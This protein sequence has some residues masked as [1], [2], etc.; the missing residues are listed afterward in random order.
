MGLVS[1][2]ILTIPLVFGT[3]LFAQDNA[4]ETHSQPSP[5]PVVCDPESFVPGPALEVLS[6][7]AGVDLRQYLRDVARSIRINWQAARIA[8][9]QPP[10]NKA[11]CAIIEFAIQKDGKLT[12]MK[13]V[14]SSGDATLERAAW[15]GITDSAPFHP[16]LEQFTGESLGLRFHFR[17]NPGQ[18]GQL[19][20]VGPGSGEWKSASVGDNGSGGTLEPQTYQGEP[21]YRVGSGVT[22]PKGTYMPN[23]SYTDRARKK[24]LRGTVVLA[25]IVTPE[26][27]V[28][29]AKVVR[30]FDPEM[31]QNA[32]NTV[33]TWKFEPAS[34][35]GK[36]VAVA[37]N[38]EASF[39]LY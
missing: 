13:L 24:K 8:D 38:V 31:D 30:G 33:C 22:A 21:V 28:G 6:D 34:K 35:D 27:N 16:L 25:I 9:A 39:N 7:T 15:A 3:F 11:G 10:L 18:R 5:A 19:M 14:Q 20:P 1:R 32:L 37:I 26:G 23:P 17:Y 12:G 2:F 29:D 4:R 36:P